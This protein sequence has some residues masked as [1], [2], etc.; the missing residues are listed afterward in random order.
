[1]SMA[2]NPKHTAIPEEDVPAQLVRRG[3]LLVRAQHDVAARRNKV[4]TW[5]E[6]SLWFAPKTFGIFQP[7]ALGS[8]VLFFFFFPCPEGAI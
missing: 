6:P 5:F 8:L 4:Q 7:L 3:V 2:S 1:M